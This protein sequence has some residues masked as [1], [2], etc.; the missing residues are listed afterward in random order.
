MLFR[1]LLWGL[2]IAAVWSLIKPRRA[3]RGPTPAPK[4]LPMLRCAHCDVHVPLDEATIVD[5]VPYC[6]EAHARLGMKKTS[7]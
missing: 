6:S 4:A 2:V 1:L 7:S 3:V 5:G